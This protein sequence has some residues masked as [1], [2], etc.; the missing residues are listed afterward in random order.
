MKKIDKYKFFNLPRRLFLSFG[1]PRIYIQQNSTN[2]FC[3]K[4]K[5][6]FINK[7]IYNKS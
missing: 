4:L 7:W 3:N 5:A 2:R 1:L 6:Y